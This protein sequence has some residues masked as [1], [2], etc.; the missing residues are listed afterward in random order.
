VLGPWVNKPW[1]NIVATVIVSVLLELSLIL[2]IST[3]FT[4]IDVT[5]LVVVLTAILIV[6][7]V[8]AAVLIVRSPARAPQMSADEKANWRMPALALLQPAKW[9]LGRRIAVLAMQVYLGIAVLLLVVKAVQIALGH[10]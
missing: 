7:M 3:I 9:S 6:A 10:H 2:I 5:R 8:V 1:L 4:S